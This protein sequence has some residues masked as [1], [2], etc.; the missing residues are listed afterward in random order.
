MII[1]ELLNEDPVSTNVALVQSTASP[2]NDVPVSLS[3]ESPSVSTVD[4][5]DLD[6]L[7]KIVSTLQT[8]DHADDSGVQL[9][10]SSSVPVS[11]STESS[12]P[13]VEKKVLSTPDITIEKELATSLV[14][15]LHIEDSGSLDNS[16]ELSTNVPPLSTEEYAEYA[17]LTRKARVANKNKP[18]TPE[19]RAEYEK[20]KT[21]GRT[22][23]RKILKK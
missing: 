3:T 4:N 23:K 12:V 17:E 8:P 11:L 21:G 6:T 13:T 16:Q 10:P 18:D 9:Q 19:T 22:R 14:N 2:G 15:T 5:K 20:L 7:K 1:N